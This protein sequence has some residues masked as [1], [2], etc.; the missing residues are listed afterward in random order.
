MTTTAAPWTDTPAGPAR[1]FTVIAGQARAVFSEWGA[2]L[3]ELWVPDRQGELADVV[4]G[5]AE[6]A[7]YLD[8]PG[9]LGAVVGRFAN[10]IAAGRAPIAGAVFELE[11]NRPGVHLHGGSRGFHARLWRGEPLADGVRFSR[12]SPAGES[13]YPGRLEV[14][15]SYTL[16]ARGREVHLDVIVEART[17]APT[18]VSIAQHAY[19]NLAG[20][21][22]GPVFDHEVR[23]P[24]F[25]WL[26]VDADLVPTGVLRDPQGAL[27]LSH[28]TRLLG[29]LGTLPSELEATRG[30]DH[31]YVVATLPAAEVRHPASGRSLTVSTDQ[32]ALQFYTAGHLDDLPGKAGARYQ[33]HQGLCLETQ[34]YPN[35]PN[36]PFPGAE[37]HPRQRYRRSTRYAFG[38]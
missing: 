10:R 13:G 6:P 27:D 14:S 33:R 18:L 16:R 4:L 2:T 25:H 21:D 34:A 37:L 7:S 38:S 11:C 28:W 1:R 15:V 22:S 24:A 20:H 26:E 12:T 36:L 35:A 23:I 19:F 17:D 5:H 9:H 32:P 29:P 8:N 30:F 31:C 3:L